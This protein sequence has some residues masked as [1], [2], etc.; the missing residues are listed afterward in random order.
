MDESDCCSYAPYDI[1]TDS[2]PPLNK[3]QR[4]LLAAAL[5]SCSTS[6]FSPLCASWRSQHNMALAPGEICGPDS[7]GAGVTL[8]FTP[9][10]TV[11]SY[12]SGLPTLTPSKTRHTIPSQGDAH[13]GNAGLSDVV[14]SPLG[15]IQIPAMSPRIGLRFCLLIPAQSGTTGPCES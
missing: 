13:G 4:S 6:V 10:G 14:A 5:M 9:A 12:S 15:D 2:G 11:W 1:V 3:S 7:N 8:T